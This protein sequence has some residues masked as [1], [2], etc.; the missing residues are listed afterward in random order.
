MMEGSGSVQIMTY[1]NPDPGGPKTYE[2]GST[3]LILAILKKQNNLQFLG[4]ALIFGW[5]SF[6]SRFQ[7]RGFN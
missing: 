2:F 5:G 1:L 6:T 3:T 4:G 7:I